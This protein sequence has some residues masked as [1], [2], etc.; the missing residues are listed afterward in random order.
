MIIMNTKRD[1]LRLADRS[2]TGLLFTGLLVL[3]GCHQSP[4]PSSGA[5]A[6]AP[7]GAPAA[8]SAPPAAAPA[9]HVDGTPHTDVVENAWRGAGLAPEG[10][11]PLQPVPFGASYCEQGRVQT[12]DTLVCEYRD[13]DA[14]GKGQAGLLE[15]WGREGGH[16]GVAFHSKLTMIGVIDRA[17]HDPNG[18]VIHQVIDTFRKL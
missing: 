8:A 1:R 10:F 18:K 9:Q 3:G 2:V 13:Q 17:R 11:A 5:A 14:L 15:Q 6:S 4:A 7:P 12:I 16:T